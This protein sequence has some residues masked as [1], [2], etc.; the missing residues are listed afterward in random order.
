MYTGAEGIRKR[1]KKVYTQFSLNG[2]K[3]LFYVV[4]FSITFKICPINALTL[5]C[6]KSKMSEHNDKRMLEE[7]QVRTNEC[8]NIAVP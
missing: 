4:R 7:W 1:S 6:R 8:R 2:L 5:V 3:T